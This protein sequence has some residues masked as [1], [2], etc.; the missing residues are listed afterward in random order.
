M[1][2]LSFGLALSAG[3][4]QV[5]DPQLSSPQ[6]S[7][8][9]NAYLFDVVMHANSNQ[10]S[11]NDEVI[12]ARIEVYNNTK[13]ETVVLLE[14]HSASNFQVNLEKGN[15][16]SMM[17]RKEG[18]FNKRMEAYVDIDGCI[19]CLDGI[20]EV[21]PNVS[22]AM[23]DG[24]SAGALLAQV[25]L[26]KI[27][28][29]KV[30]KIDNIYY[31]YDKWDIRPDAAKELNKVVTVLEE[32]PGILMELGSHTCSKGNDTYNQQLSEKRA[33]AAVE[34]I[35]NKGVDGERISFKGYGESALTNGCKNGI[36]C[37][38]NRHKK[39]RRTELK[40]TGIMDIGSIQYKSLQDIVMKEREGNVSMMSKSN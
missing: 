15:H 32:H 25:N 28:L 26:E 3:W 4:S 38:E 33:K 35:K 10:L 40:I 11:A 24:Q 21:T 5:S 12:G 13:D 30:I 17:V 22:D 16:Y 20:G 6:I 31:D 39:N 18:Y 23:T 1:L 34:Y 37:S 2:T 9:G 7:A 14:N 19:L 29:N 8:V 36:N 27:E